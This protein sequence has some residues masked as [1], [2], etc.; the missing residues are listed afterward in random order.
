[1]TFSTKKLKESQVE[2]TVDLDKEDLTYIFQY[3]EEKRIN[4]EEIKNLIISWRKKGELPSEIKI[5]AS[6][7]NEKQ[8]QSHI[9]ENTLDICGTGG[10]R[11]NTLNISTLA[12]IIASS[13]GVKVIKHSGRST[14]SISGSVD[15]LSDF[16]LNIDNAKDIK[17]KCFKNHGLMFVSSKLLKDVFGEVK[18]ICKELNTPGFVN[19]LG[20]LTNPYLTDFHLLGV[21]SI[22]WG[23][24]LA[25]VC[26]KRVLIV[27]SKL[28]NGMVLDELSFSGKNYIWKIENGKVEEEILDPFDFGFK[29][30]DYE[31]LIVK[32]KEEAK[33]N[34]ELILRGKRGK[35]NNLEDKANIVALNAGAALYLSKKVKSITEGYEKALRHT[36]SGTVW[37]H[38]NAFLNC[39]KMEM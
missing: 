2:L 7:L 38:F 11:S 20:P 12:A 21:S 10:D 28:K 22:E 26:E 37:E 19:L 35:I 31:N 32:N 14:T 4:S 16:G 34:F 17:E 24:L 8:G 25:S 36:Q 29:I 1:V 18:K 23:K 30:V 13:C 15:V 27:C 39:N 6:L 5:L 9:A 3:F 33:E